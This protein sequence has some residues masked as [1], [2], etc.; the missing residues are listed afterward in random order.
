MADSK[1]KTQGDKHPQMFGT[2]FPEYTA[3]KSKGPSWGIQQGQNAGK[4]AGEKKGK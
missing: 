4:G 1:I 2:K 3:T